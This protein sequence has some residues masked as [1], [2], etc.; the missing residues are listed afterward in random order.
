MLHDYFRANPGSIFL[1]DGLGALLSTLLL[2]VIAYFEGVFGMP[3][4]ALY[5]LVPVTTTFAVFSLGS[6]LLSPT[7]WKRYL[8][9]IAIANI[10]YCCLTLA[11]LLYFF[12]KLTTLG[13]AYF[14]IEIV[15]ILLLSR[16]ELRLACNK[17]GQ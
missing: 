7:N 16:I 15:V 2:L 14:F 13:I 17:P 8:A 9:L 4:N 3:K 10:L 1:I 11:L 6:Y 5:G 12:R